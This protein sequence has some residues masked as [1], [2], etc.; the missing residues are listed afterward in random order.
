MADEE[1]RAAV[2]AFL[3]SQVGPEWLAER[4]EEEFENMFEQIFEQG[5]LTSAFREFHAEHGRYP[6]F[7]EMCSTDGSSIGMLKDMM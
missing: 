1:L 5:L 7:E 6:E 3:R 2:R 4:G